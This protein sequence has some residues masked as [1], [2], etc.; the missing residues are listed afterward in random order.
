MAGQ[1]PYYV[2]LLFKPD[3]TPFYVGKGK[4]NRISGHE[5]EARRFLKSEKWKGMNTFKLNTISKMWSNNEIVYYQIDSWHDES[6]GAS[7]REIELVGQYGRRILKTGPLTN[8]RDGG[9]LMTQTDRLIFREKARQ[10]YIDNPEAA[11]ELG[12]KRRQYYID[13]PEAREHLSEVLQNYC[14]EHPEFIKRLQL[15]KN[16][17]IDTKPEEYAAAERKRLEI[18][19]SESHREKV[20]EIMRGYFQDHPDERERLKRQGVAYFEDKPEAIEQARQNSIRNNTGQYLIDWYASDD[21]EIR[22][23]REEKSKSHSEWLSGWHESEE[24]KK[25]TK[26]AAIKRNEKFRTEDHREHM[27]KKT[28]EYIKNNPEADKL[29]RAKAAET[30]SVTWAAKKKDRQ[31]HLLNIQEELFALGKIEKKREHI[32]NNVLRFWK[33]KGFVTTSRPYS[34]IHQVDDANFPVEI[35]E[36]IRQREKDS[37]RIKSNWK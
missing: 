34:I 27:A 16:N 10:Y 25:T 12:E 9:D 8:I 6:I 30:A 29:R 28:A 32:D 15:E 37:P 36:V 20:A 11:K 3:G 22:A 23:A 26:Q 13:H 4:N 19:K 7:N 14:I 33:K 35:M 17:W 1:K 31:M 21:P 5:A 2:Y 24:G 18:C